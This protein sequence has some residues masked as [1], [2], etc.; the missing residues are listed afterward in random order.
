MYISYYSQHDCPSSKFD[1]LTAGGRKA[2]RMGMTELDKSLHKVI[3][4]KVPSLME[5][6]EP[7]ELFDAQ[8]YPFPDE[9]SP[10]LKRPL[11][12]EFCWTVE[13]LHFRE[14]EEDQKNNWFPSHRVK[15][16]VDVP[17][18]L[19]KEY[20]QSQKNT[21][22]AV[23]GSIDESQ[24]K[25]VVMGFKSQVSVN[26]LPHQSTQMKLRISSPGFSPDLAGDF[27][28]EGPSQER[29]Y[30]DIKY[31]IAAYSRSNI[32]IPAMDDSDGN[33]KILRA[34]L[35]LVHIC[36]VWMCACVCL[37]V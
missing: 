36:I 11:E 29:I 30:G 4:E 13:G 10:S 24:T 35:S 5:V 37:C 25:I 28:A 2:T 7:T 31:N 1:C 34:H 23:D 18:A 15:K 33:A 16:D 17:A 12:L 14:T 32:P 27:E 19:V 6:L 22:V 3:C 26:S 21:S 20:F 8:E 9:W